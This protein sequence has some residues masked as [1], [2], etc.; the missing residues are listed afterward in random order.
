MRPQRGHDVCDSISV[1]SVYSLRQNACIA[2]KTSKI[3][4]ENDHFFSLSQIVQHLRESVRDVVVGEDRGRGALGVQHG[5]EVDEAILQ[6]EKVDTRF[7][8]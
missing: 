8:S 4:W 2:V 1:M 6:I 5:F 3:W 7:K